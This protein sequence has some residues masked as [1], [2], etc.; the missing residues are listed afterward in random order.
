MKPDI[1]KIASVTLNADGHLLIVKPKG[2]ST[3]ISLGGKL[4][5]GET[6]VEC[7]K[8]EIKEEL[9]VETISEPEFFYE[10]DLEMTADGSGKTVIVKFY[11]VEVDAHLVPD[12]DEI[13]S[14]MWLSKD[15]FETKVKGNHSLVIGSGLEKFAIPKLIE[16]DLL[17]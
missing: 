17:K 4:E 8:R 5:E 6:E 3:W 9:N 13:E 2:K 7:L 14:F 10:T 12:G 11:T 15:D 16:L 1:I